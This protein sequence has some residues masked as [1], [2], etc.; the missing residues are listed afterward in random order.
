MQ[1]RAVEDARFSTPRATRPVAPLVAPTG[2]VPRVHSRPMATWSDAAATGA[3]ARPPSAST[4]HRARVALR[5]GWQRRRRVGPRPG[6]PSRRTDPGVGAP[7]RELSA[8]ESAPDHLGD[9]GAA[10]ADEWAVVERPMVPP[11]DAQPVE[12]AEYEATA[13][14]L[15]DAHVTTPSASGG[16]PPRGRM[17]APSRAIES[18]PRPGFVRSR[19][20]RSR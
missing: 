3:A 1:Q 14:L 5:T 9:D 10:A 17:G 18:S 12:I 6:D 19:S 7:P 20:P 15:A 8:M 11:P 16:P 13:C 4:V 2:R